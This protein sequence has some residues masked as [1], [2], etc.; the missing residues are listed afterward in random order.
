MQAHKLEETYHYI[1]GVTENDQAHTGRVEKSRCVLEETDS[2]TG[3]GNRGK[4]REGETIFDICWWLARKQG[5]CCSK[6]I[7]CVPCMCW[8]QFCDG[9]SP[10]NTD[11]LDK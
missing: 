1:V 6:V 5:T 3:E 2:R 9:V 8:C 11:M 4:E 10:S 7:C